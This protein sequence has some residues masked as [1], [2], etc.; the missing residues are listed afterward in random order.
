[1]TQFRFGRVGGELTLSKPHTI[2]V[3]DNDTIELSLSVRSENED[4]HQAVCQTAVAYPCVDEPQI[5]VVFHAG[6]STWLSGFFEPVECALDRSYKTEGAHMAEMRARLRRPPGWATPAFDSQVACQLL[7][8]DISFGS[9]YETMWW[10]CPGDVWDMAG[11][12]AG[13]FDT[14]GLADANTLNLWYAAADPA[15]DFTARWGCPPAAWYVGA[16]AIEAQLAGTDWIAVPGRQLAAGYAWRVGN[17]LVRFGPS[18]T[19][20][21]FDVEHWDGTAWRSKTWNL[22]GGVGGTVD[23]VHGVTILRNSPA[24][25]CVLVSLG[26]SAQGPALGALQLEV[27]LR[28][29]SRTLFCRLACDS[30]DTWKVARDSVDAAQAIPTGVSS[31]IMDNADDANGNRFMAMTPAVHTNDLTNGSVRL[32]SSGTQFAFGLSLEVGGSGASA[33]DDYITLQQQYFAAQH[34]R[35]SFTGR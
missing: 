21:R 19:A 9:G 29:G 3:K 14:R 18:A 16:A 28:R 7:D 31:G 24:E 11:L 10:A 17:Q 6:R 25:V 1:M 35:V 15:V 5:P 13:T 4:R 26:I 8:N 12:P 23:Q 22:S 20:G 32:T 33:P 34:E 30:T 27:S 2:A